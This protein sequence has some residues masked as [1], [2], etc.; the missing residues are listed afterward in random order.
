MTAIFFFADT[1]LP[2]ATIYLPMPTDKLVNWKFNDVVIKISFAFYSSR[3]LLKTKISAWSVAVYASILS[4]VSICRSRWVSKVLL[5]W[6]SHW[7]QR[8]MIRMISKWM[9]WTVV[10]WCH[11][12]VQRYPLPWRH[13]AIQVGYSQQVCMS[14]FTNH[15]DSV[16]NISRAMMTLIKPNNTFLIFLI[17]S[18]LL[19][20]KL[21]SI[22]T[23]QN[24]NILDTCMWQFCQETNYLLDNTW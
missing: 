8:P 20:L 24:N 6:T 23:T 9:L 4:K 5:A 12:K 17:P 21:T 10:E 18:P 14:W 15:W 11:W 19:L 22:I 16:G 1:Q 2:L 3:F 7:D 13:L